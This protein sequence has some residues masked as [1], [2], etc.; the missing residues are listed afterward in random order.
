MLYQLCTMASRIKQTLIE[1]RKSL[2]KMITEDNQEEKILDELI[3]LGSI[4]MTVDLIKESKLGKTVSNVKD[5]FDQNESKNISN[6]A[7]E[8]LVDW[9]RIIEHQKSAGQGDHKHHVVDVANFNTKTSVVASS[10]PDLKGYIDGLA[11]TRRSIVGVFSNIFKVSANP[12]HADSIAVGIEEALQVQFPSDESS[13]TKQYTVRAKQLSFNIKKN[14]VSTAM[15]VWPCIGLIA[16]ALTASFQILRENIINGHIPHKELVHMSASELASQEQRVAREKMNLEN[17]DERRLDW[18]AE[19]K[20][21]LQ[22][23]IGIDP[24]NTWEYDNGEDGMSEPDAD[25]PDI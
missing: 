24:A 6:K 2:E 7:K 13:T 22:L 8:I 10:H 5:K 15:I 18:L 14:D 21:E 19:H 3:V 4:P 16:A 1:M 20:E 25:P 11:P 12:A 23:D 17:I 9:K